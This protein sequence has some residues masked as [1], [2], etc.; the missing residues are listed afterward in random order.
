MRIC[1]SKI[2]LLKP[3]FYSVLGVGALWAKVSKK[4][5]LILQKKENVDW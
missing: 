4:E 5:I 2:G 3:L 1:F